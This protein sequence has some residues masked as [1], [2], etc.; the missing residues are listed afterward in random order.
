MEVVADH[1]AAP[2]VL[3]ARVIA[4]AGVLVWAGFLFGVIHLS[5]AVDTGPVAG[6]SYVLRTGW[7]LLFTVLVA[8]PLAVLAVRPRL[9]ALLLQVAVVGVCVGVAALVGTQLLQLLPALVLV[10]NAAFVADLSRGSVRPTTGWTVPRLDAVLAAA[11]VAAAPVA[12]LYAADMAAAA[13]QGP[14]PLDNSMGLDHWGMQAAVPLAV[15]ATAVVVAAGTRHRW[16]GTLVAAWT[17]AVTAVTAVTAVWLGAVSLA[18]PEH[19]A[20]LGSLWSLW[21]VVWGVAFGLLASLRWRSQRGS[22]TAGAR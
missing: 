6:G 10:L 7:G 1:P 12:L 9:P 20:G 13:R 16:G 22:R 15:L 4:G 8:A 19:S 18:Y 2:D 3:I 17:V 14:P 5:S 21:A 11:T